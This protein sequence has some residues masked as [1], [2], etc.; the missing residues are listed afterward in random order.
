MKKLQRQQIKDFTTRFYP[1]KVSP[2]WLFLETMSRSS[3]ALFGDP[4][5]VHSPSFVRTKV[6]LLY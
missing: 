3:L 4:Y 2:L 1:G 6:S 5:P